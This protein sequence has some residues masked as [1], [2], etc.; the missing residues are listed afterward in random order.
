MCPQIIE[1]RIHRI[2]ADVFSIPV[3]NIGPESS[4]QTIEKWDSVGHLNLVL[5]LEEAFGVAFSPEQI[6]D[7]TDV[8]KIISTV[9]GVDH[10]RSEP[11][12]LGTRE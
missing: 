9:A 7:M 1:Q 4:P 8:Q 11:R 6:D 3:L 10:G 2:V 5:A 12:S